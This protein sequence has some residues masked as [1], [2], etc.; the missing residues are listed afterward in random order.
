MKRIFLFAMLV[1]AAL[2][3]VNAQNS[4]RFR[5]G[6][7][8]GYNNSSIS[9]EGTSSMSGFNAGVKVE[10][11]LPKLH[12]AYLTAGFKITTKNWKT[13]VG[14][15]DDDGWYSDDDDYSFMN[16]LTSYSVTTK[17]K[18]YYLDIPVHFGYKFNVAP[19]AALFVEVG[20]YFDFGLFGK[21]TYT[22]NAGGSKLTEPEENIDNVFTEDEC[23][24][25]FDVGLGGKIGAEIAKHYQISLGYDFGLNNVLKDIYEFSCKNRNFTVNVAYVF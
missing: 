20:P 13:T 9:T 10:M 11:G 8:A 24:K 6:V 16:G 1:F 15:V 2:L 25:R 3:S 7:E 22:L 23:M 14:W 5:F 19:K 21:C 17:L 4:Q 12:G 18:P